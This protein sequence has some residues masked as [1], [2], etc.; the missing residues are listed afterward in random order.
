MFAWCL[1]M[2]IAA[3]SVG[4]QRVGEVRPRGIQARDTE[5][6]A[7]STVT[8]TSTTSTTVLSTSTNVVWVTGV[9][10][11]TGTGTGSVSVYVSG[12]GSSAP[13]SSVATNINS[14]SSMPSLASASVAPSSVTSASASASALATSSIPPSS[15]TSSSAPNS[16]SYTCPTGTAATLP[17]N[18][19]LLP[20]ITAADNNGWGNGPPANLSLTCGKSTGIWVAVFPINSNSWIYP[21][22]IHYVTVSGFPIQ[23]QSISSIEIEILSESPWA[24]LVPPTTGSLEGVTLSSLE[25]CTVGTVELNVPSGMALYDMTT[26]NLTVGPANYTSLRDCRSGGLADDATFALMGYPNGSSALNSEPSLLAHCNLT[27]FPSSGDTGRTINLEPASP[28]ATFSISNWTFTPLGFQCETGPAGCSTS[29]GAAPIEVTAQQYVR[30]AVDHAW[31]NGPVDA[32]GPESLNMSRGCDAAPGQIHSYIYDTDP[33]WTTA[34]WTSMIPCNITGY[35]FNVDTTSITFQ[36]T[37]PYWSLVSMPSGNTFMDC[38]D[39]I[40][41]ADA[42]SIVPLPNGG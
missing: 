41:W 31:N 35:P 21:E 36:N 5:G 6:C 23:P 8:V 33:N 14:G 11:Q 18:L 32:Q 16:T 20:N 3:G 29:W 2:A 10:V 25:D 24:T 34:K 19:M 15:A 13:T 40:P 17:I 30:L 37:M 4:A 39:P 12:S 1:L 27:G 42:A 26:A 7:Y 28:W 9:A 38:G 22:T